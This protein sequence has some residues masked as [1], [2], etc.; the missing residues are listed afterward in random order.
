MR[1]PAVP[2]SADIRRGEIWLVSLDPAAGSTVRMTRPVIV[3]S[4]DSVNRVRG[5]VVV[6]PV[7]RAAAAY[8]PMVVAAG[9]VGQGCFAVCDQVRT[10]DQAQLVWRQ[11][12]MKA[13]EM[14]G[15]EA[16]MCAVLGL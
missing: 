2:H 12:Q 11:G 6:V 15:I 5:T 7:A 8:P 10:V 1:K 14:R 9:S 16:G 13:T 4:E 3:V